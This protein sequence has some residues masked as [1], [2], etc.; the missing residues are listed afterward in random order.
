MEEIIIDKILANEA[1]TSL[2]IVGLAIYFV[3]VIR[4]IEFD[5]HSVSDGISDIRSQISYI[6]GKD[7]GREIED[8]K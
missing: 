8:T 4:R 6:R 3:R 1:P 7:D 5:L 2:L